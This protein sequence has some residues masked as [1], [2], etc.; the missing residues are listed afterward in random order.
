MRTTR[1]NQGKSDIRDRKASGKPD[2]ARA[3]TGPS[4]FR[5]ATESRK[6]VEPRKAAAQTRRDAPSGKAERAGYPSRTKRPNESARDIN[7]AGH[8]EKSSGVGGMHR[9]RKITGSGSNFQAR[10]FSGSRVRSIKSAEPVKETDFLSGRNPVMEALKSGRPISK[11]YAAAGE[12]QGSIR[13]IIALAKEKNIPVQIAEQARLDA[14]SLGIRNQGVVAMVSPVPYASM[15]EI[16]AVASAKNEKPCIVLLDQLKDPQNLGA[17]LRTVDAAGAHGVLI[18]QRRSCQLSAAVAK[19]SAGAIEYVK[20]AQIGNIAR[21]LEDL[22]KQGF[23]VVGADPEQGT[24]YHEVDLTGPVVVVIG[25]E[26]EG[27]ARLTKEHCDMLV[28][29]PMRG[30]VQS[31]NASVASAILLYEMIRQRGNMA[32]RGDRSP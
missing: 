24:D 5:K 17:V 4:E 2:K 27:M 32:A 10:Q 13:E 18:P 29:I 28:R 25:D 9:E 20:V 6:S 26:G 12:H 15:D 8:A 16:I 30:K 23:W 14:M 11:L 22:K 7:R 21:S 3:A 31:L 19:A 1:D